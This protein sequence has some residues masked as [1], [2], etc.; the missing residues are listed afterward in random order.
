MYFDHLWIN[1]RLNFDLFVYGGGKF[2]A[3]TVNNYRYTVEQRISS[4]LPPPP[5]IF[6]K[7]RNRNNSWTGRRTHAF[8]SVSDSAFDFVK[9]LL[10]NDEL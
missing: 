2:I 3:Q 10:D 8:D 6:I 1:P 5:P 9:S 4:L 7:K